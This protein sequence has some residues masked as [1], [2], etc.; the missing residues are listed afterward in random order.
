LRH[1]IMTRLQSINAP[2]V[3]VEMVRHKVTLDEATERRLL[4]E[5]LPPGLKLIT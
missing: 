5:S 1:R 2:P 4:G 3:W